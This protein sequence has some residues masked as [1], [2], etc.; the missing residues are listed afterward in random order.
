[1]TRKKRHR[2]QAYVEQIVRW[3]VYHPGKY[4]KKHSYAATYLEAF[5]ERSSTWGCDKS[6]AIRFLSRDDAE[7]VFRQATDGWKDRSYAD[8]FQIVPADTVTT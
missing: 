4:E 3:I 8:G 6:R 1:M 7:H 2:G 5:S